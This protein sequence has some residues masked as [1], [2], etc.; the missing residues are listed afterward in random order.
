MT[1]NKPAA[2]YVLNGQ[3]EVYVRSATNRLY[4]ILS[5]DHGNNWKTWDI[6]P[7]FTDKSPAIA[8][9]ADGKYRYMAFQADVPV[10]NSMEIG[11][12]G[13]RFTLVSSE[14][15]GYDW[16]KHQT[17][18]SGTFKSGP[19][20]V[21]TPDGNTVIVFGQGNDDHFW[22]AGSRN[23]AVS[24][25]WMWIAL[26]H[27]VFKSEPAAAMSADGNTIL[28]FGL[29]Q[30]NKCWYA[31]SSNGGNSWNVYWAPIADGSFTSS[32]AAA[33]SADGKNVIVIGKGKDKKFWYNISK[34]AGLT[35]GAHFTPIG[36]GVFL[37]GPAVCCS[38]DFKYIQV[39]GV[40][41]DNKIW[42]AGSDNNGKNWAGWWP[43]PGNINF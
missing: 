38:W 37:G 11:P 42:R 27:G 2:V 43:I 32:F 5:Y 34:D 18:G 24:W 14:F 33:I 21:C 17:L 29:G 19:A 15:F 28:V 31:Q 9:T 1:N 26:K 8:A 16:G 30:D 40:G 39:F 36:E 12:A 3:L 20:I 10:G 13:N 7:D 22:W 25:Q 35:W 41:N 4:H 23:K 6:L